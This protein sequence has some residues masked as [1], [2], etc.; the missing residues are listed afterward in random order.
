V[1]EAGRLL[2]RNV[3]DRLH[4]MQGGPVGRTMFN[5]TPDIRDL[6]Q[7]FASIFALSRRR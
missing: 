7:D 4:R 6:G 3:P 5:F 2:A 1:E